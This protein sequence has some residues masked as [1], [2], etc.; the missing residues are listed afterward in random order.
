MSD[1]APNVSFMRI[2]RAIAEG[3]AEV[4]GTDVDA[5]L[6]SHL[7]DN[8]V[9]TRS[10]PQ[11]AA[12]VNIGQP[13]GDCIV[14][15]AGGASGET[16]SA[17]ALAAAKK[18]ATEF[19]VDEEPEQPKTFELETREDGVTNFEAL[20]GERTLRFRTTDGDVMV[21]VGGKIV[22]QSAQLAPHVS[23][24]APA[25]NPPA[26]SVIEPQV[27]VDA[28]EPRIEEPV[29][30]AAPAQSYSKAAAPAGGSPR[31]PGLIAG[32]DVEFTAVLGGTTMRLGEI[33]SLQRDHVVVLD[34][35]VGE[36]VVVYVNGMPF[37]HAQ[38]V[39]VD[40][41]Y[42]IEVIELIESPESTVAAA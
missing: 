24:S 26:D 35:E 15:V 40:D 36:P 9:S 12:L 27:V 28:A 32:V 5:G 2:T 37:A 16:I 3:L 14:A 6:V 7:D 18:L 19:G 8:D 38:L 23:D 42:G 21:I 41:E 34:E 4:L 31:W 30:E 1:S 25:P 17:A 33:A 11:T 13:L 29:A 39:V 22:E 10:Y 20:I